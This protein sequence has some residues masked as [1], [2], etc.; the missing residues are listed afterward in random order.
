MNFGHTEDG[1]SIEDEDRG[2]NVHIPRRA[3][4][5]CEIELEGIGRGPLSEFTFRDECE[6]LSE[7]R[8]RTRTDMPEIPNDGELETETDEN[9]YDRLVADPDSQP[10][11]YRREIRARG[12][13]DRGEFD[14]V[15]EGLGYDPDAGAHNA[16]LLMLQRIG[17]IEREGQGGSQIIRWM[18]E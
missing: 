15:A 13:V 10:A 8:D 18:G 14:N 5:E 16:S 6:S 9:F 3:M 11:R 7:D 2:I 4:N 12:Q 17:E 1:V